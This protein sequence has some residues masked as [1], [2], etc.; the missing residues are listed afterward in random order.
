VSG[1]DCTG[2]GAK[3]QMKEGVAGTLLM[4][5]TGH[6]ANQ[7]VATFKDINS[8]VTETHLSR[9]PAS[10]S[11][12]LAASDPVTKDLVRPLNQSCRHSVWPYD[13]KNGS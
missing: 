9:S 3:G 6:V 13:V 10:L 1:F 11:I 12:T 5:G 8:I 4:A 2:S 7:Q